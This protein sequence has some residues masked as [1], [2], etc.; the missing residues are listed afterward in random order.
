MMISLVA[1]ILG[2]IVVAAMLCK[3]MVDFVDKREMINSVVLMIGVALL[4]PVF[5]IWILWGAFDIW[6]VCNKNQ[7][8]KISK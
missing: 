8:W 1:Y 2:F 5:G 3:E 6:M 4:W 7:I